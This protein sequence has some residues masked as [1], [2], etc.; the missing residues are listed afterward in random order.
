MARPIFT[1]L[2]FGLASACWAFTKLMRE[3]MPTWRCKGWR[4]SGYIDD[5][6]HAHQD[7]KTLIARRT[8]ILNLLER[9]G[10]CVNREKSML[11]EP[12]QRVRYLGMLIDTAQGV[13]IVPEDKRAFL[14]ECIRDALGKRRA[15]QKG[16]RT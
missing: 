4:C 6:I 12:Q 5:Q 10:F 1:Q 9:L 7:L 14:L 15:S 8:E 16:Y 3:V 13:F 2:P 11:G